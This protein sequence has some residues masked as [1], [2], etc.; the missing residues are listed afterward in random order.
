MEWM[1]KG[2]C[3]DGGQEIDH[4]RAG[5]YHSIIVCTSIGKKNV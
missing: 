2:D 4:G 3:I 1:A 5:T